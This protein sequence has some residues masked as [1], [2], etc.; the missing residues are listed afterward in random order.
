MWTRSAKNENGKFT[1]TCIDWNGQ[2]FSEGEF[3]SA[4]EADRAGEH[5]ERMMTL[6]MTDGPAPS[7]D[8]V[9]AEMDDDELLAELSA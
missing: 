1:F 8:D 5:A 2:L 4:Q 6:A 9:F 3:A 7:L